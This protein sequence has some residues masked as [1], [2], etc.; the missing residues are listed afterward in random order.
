[1]SKKGKIQGNIFQVDKESLQNIPIKIPIPEMKDKILN[2]YIWINN[3]KKQNRFTDTR[4]WEQKIDN[5]IYQI[6]DLTDAE[7]NFIKNFELEFRMSG[8]DNDN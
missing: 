6:Y 4:N 2:L 7:I 3:A 8:A 1:M 5:T